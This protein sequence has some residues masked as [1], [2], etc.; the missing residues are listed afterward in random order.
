MSS[1]VRQLLA[2]RRSAL[3]ARLESLEALV[4]RDGFAATWNLEA[5]LIR[6]ELAFLS[7]LM[8]TLIAE[9]EIR[10]AARSLRATI[11]GL[12]RGGDV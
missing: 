2:G 6:D 10:V 4:E 3:M 8:R 11:A 9:S 7:E 5:G 12:P 1:P